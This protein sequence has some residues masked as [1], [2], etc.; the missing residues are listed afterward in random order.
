MLHFESAESLSIDMDLDQ[1]FPFDANPHPLFFQFNTGSVP[2]TYY[3][4]YG[5]ICRGITFT[6]F[7]N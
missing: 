3:S 4:A 1:A 7:S 6:Y 2:G 5:E